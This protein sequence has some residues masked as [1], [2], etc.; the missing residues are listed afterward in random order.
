MFP[1][2]MGP[3]PPDHDGGVHAAIGILICSNR[4]DRHKEK[5]KL[6]SSR[7][8]RSVHANIFMAS[9]LGGATSNSI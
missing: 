9:A 3:L 6:S 8:V 4:S 7:K 2:P 5:Q 1:K